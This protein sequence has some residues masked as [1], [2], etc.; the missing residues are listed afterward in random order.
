MLNLRCDPY[1][2]G[3]V[4]NYSSEQDCG[5]EPQ[6]VRAFFGFLFARSG[7]GAVLFE[8]ESFSFGFRLFFFGAGFLVGGDIGG[9]FAFVRF[10]FAENLADVFGR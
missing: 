6:K 7:A 1:N 4:E 9:A 5:G 8:C 3:D 2:Q 10:F